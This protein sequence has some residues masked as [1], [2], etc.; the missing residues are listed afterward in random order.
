MPRSVSKGPYVEPRLLSRIEHHPLLGRR[1]DNLD[2]LWLTRRP[3]PQSA[4]NRGE[5]SSAAR[6]LA[7]RNVEPMFHVPHLWRL[8]KRRG[9]R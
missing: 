3:S 1:N 2:E 9:G 4:R 6:G 7:V 5:C 8:V